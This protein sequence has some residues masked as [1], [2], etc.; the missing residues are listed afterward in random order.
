MILKKLNLA[1]ITFLIFT[2][3]S[4]TQQQKKELKINKERVYGPRIIS[5]DYDSLY[6]L[7][8][9]PE[10]KPF[11]NYGGFLL[12][13]AYQELPMIYGPELPVPE[14]IK[15]Y[16][17][18]IFKESNGQS[19][20]VDIYNKKD[21]NTPN[22]LILM[23]H[24]GY[25]KTGDKSSLTKQA[26]EFVDLGYTVASINYRLSTEHKFPSNIE[27]LR[28][29][30]L[31]LTKNAGKYNIDPN[32]IMTYGLSAGGHL[33][34]FIS[35]AANSDRAY[36]KGLNASAFKGAISI[37]GMHDLTL[38]VQREHPFTELY[39]GTTYDENSVNYVDASTV[40][41]VDEN[42]PPILIVHGSLDGSVSVKNSDNL[43]QVL[44]SRNVPYVYDRIEGWPHVMVFFSPIGERTLWNIHKFL[45]QYMP[46]DE[47]KDNE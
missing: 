13:V 39:I 38:T 18:I 45:K 10:Y 30:I 20:G 16:V 47:L 19:L 41:H 8:E 24:G 46:S 32:Q 31:F 9:P 27:D 44:K 28:D 7:K 36:T 43:A 22:P 34:A 26:V 17:D 37:F 2:S 14:N 42:D 5:I 29:G 15:K 21:D 11:K 6:Q 3:I 4:C 35:L 1:F 25:W 40:N 23:I 12:G 33:S